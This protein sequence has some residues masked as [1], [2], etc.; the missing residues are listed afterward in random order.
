[1]AHRALR[2][3]ATLAATAFL[4]LTPVAATAASGNLLRN[5]GFENGDNGVWKDNH[6]GS[7]LL[8][9][10]DPHS[11]AWIAWLGGNGVKHTDALYQRVSIPNASSA[12]LSFW[13]KL[14]TQEPADNTDDTFKVR[15]STNGTT[16]TIKKLTSAD[17]TGTYVKRTLDVSKYVGKTVV[18]RFVAT[19]D[20]GN[21]TSFQLDDTALRTS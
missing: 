19:E 18:V 14:S 2:R 16:R 7:T 5:P 20:L 8:T 10:S 13:L 17:A 12:T 6:S 9:T 21:T 4:A 1:M 15:I 11:G 3:F